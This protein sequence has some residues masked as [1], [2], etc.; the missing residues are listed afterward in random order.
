MLACARI[1][2][3]HSVV[4]GGFGAAALNMRIQDA[5]AKVVITADISIRR[6]KAIQL[7]GIVD[8]A[9]LNSSTVEHVI[10]LRRRDPPV[11]S[12]RARAGFLRDD[13]RDVRYLSSGS[14]GCRRPVLHPLYQRVHRK[15]EGYR[16]YLRGVHGRHLLHQ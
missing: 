2:A 1:G 5:E 8:E 10:V 16:A 3:I 12:P 9:I 15:T 7:K 13:G 6:G 4:F 11:G 14:H